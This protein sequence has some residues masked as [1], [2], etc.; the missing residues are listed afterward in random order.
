VKAVTRDGCVIGN[1]VGTVNFLYTLSLLAE[2]LK[3]K[4]LLTTQRYSIFLPE[5][6][7][8]L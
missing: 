4:I 5:I 1:F 6:N 3:K 8:L 7:I 2:E